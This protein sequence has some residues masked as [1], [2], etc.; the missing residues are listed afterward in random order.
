MEVSTTM[1]TDFP[2]I[3]RAIL[4]TLGSRPTAASRT[5]LAAF[6]RAEAGRQEQIAAAERR[7]ARKPPAE[8]V[9][10]VPGV[11]RGRQPARFVRIERDGDMLR[12]F[13]G[14]GLYY[15]LDSPD[16]LDVQRR[17]GRLHLIATSGSDGYA[18]IGSGT[19][20]RIKCDAARD[21][22]DLE[23]GRYNAT[24][25]GRVLEIGEAL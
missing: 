4:D 14:R 10:R 6:L 7:Q 12:I 5:T 17:N 3:H 22:V 11:K 9:K 18:V 2:L 20:P 19:M 1:S 23:D 25:R 16:R 15:D 24:V 8:R 21:L 13:I